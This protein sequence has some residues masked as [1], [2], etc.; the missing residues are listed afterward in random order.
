MKVTNE[1]LKMENSISNKHRAL[2]SQLRRPRGM[3]GKKVAER[4]NNG[5]RKMNLATIEQ[6]NLRDN[7]HV[8]EVGMGNGYFVENVLS[9]ADNVQYF[10]CDYSSWMVNESILYND[11]WVRR[12]QARFIIGDASNLPFKTNTFD[13]LFTVNTLY[14]W[15]DCTIVLNEFKRVLQQNGVLILTFRPSWVMK[16]LPVTRHGFTL[17]S[18]DEVVRMLQENGFDVMENI[19]QPD[20]DIRYEELVFKSAYSIVKARKRS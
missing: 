13:K 14:F 10:G 8:L 17:Y 15:G 18:N 19:E 6:L 16:A 7:D 12:N 11:K 9:T 20:E 3:M 4:M 1:S 2:G 5:N